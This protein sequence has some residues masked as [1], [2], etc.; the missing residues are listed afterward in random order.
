MNIR[1][2]LLVILGVSLGQAEQAYGIGSNKEVDPSNV[3]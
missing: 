2:A 3:I 1:F